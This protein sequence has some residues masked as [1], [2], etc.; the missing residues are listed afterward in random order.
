MEADV[1]KV[2]E[3]LMATLL[4]FQVCTLK[5]IV[6]RHNARI[7]RQFLHLMRAAL[8]L[9]ACPCRYSSRACEIKAEY[10]QACIDVG[11]TGCEISKIFSAFAEKDC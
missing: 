9:G 4:P 2:Q 10:M 1:E 8:F 11:C 6:Q 5:T 3:Q 7:M